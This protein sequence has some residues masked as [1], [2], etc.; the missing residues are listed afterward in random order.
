MSREKKAAPVAA[1]P[2]TSGSAIP[3][4]V[5]QQFERDQRR[6]EVNRLFRLG[7]IRPVW[8][9]RPQPMEKVD[10]RW[11]VRIGYP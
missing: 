11:V 2:A 8:K 10:G 7:R 9:S 3:E 6:R 4:D 1:T 5:W